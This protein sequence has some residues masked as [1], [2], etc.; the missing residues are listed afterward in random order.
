MKTAATQFRSGELFADLYENPG[1]PLVVIIGGSK[2]GFA[3]V[4]A[5]L[6]EYLTGKYSVLLLAYF[7]VDG[8][9]KRLS[10]IPLEYFINGIHAVKDKLDLKDEEVV[11]IG[12]SK[13]GEAV[14][15]LI[16]GYLPAGAAVACVPSCYVWQGIPGG[17]VDGMFPRSSWT[18]RKKP[19]PFM[20]MAFN[21]EI[22][23][24]VKRHI[25]VSCY[26]EAIRKNPDEKAKID[27]RNYKG[28]LL[29]LSAEEDNYWPSMAMCNA[30]VHDF[31]IDI[32]HIALKQQGHLFLEY[33]DSVRE[34]IAFLE[35][36]G[37]TG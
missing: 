15:V 4:S 29:L 8:L 6:F 7:G 9:P 18:Y 32:T 14:L 20:K 24:E 3:G 19:L 33:E 21:R 37:K 26:A 35:R 36:T 34:I 25:Y 10:R 13:G 28:K 22:L 30:M 11:L 31:S 17:F 1:K 16:S 23:R 5:F 12:N 2:G 27:L